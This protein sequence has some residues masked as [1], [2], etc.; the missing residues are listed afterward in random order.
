MRSLKRPSCGTRALAR[1]LDGRL[2]TRGFGAFAKDPFEVDHLGRGQPVAR[3]VLRREL[4]LAERR[5][6]LIH[7]LVLLRS[8]HVGA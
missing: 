8:L 6:E 4:V 5:L 7:L 1:E 3:I 2:R